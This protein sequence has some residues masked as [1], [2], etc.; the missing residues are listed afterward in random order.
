MGMLAR[1]RAWR[2]R[3]LG[4]AQFRRWAAGFPLTRPIARREARA[5]FDLCAGFVYSQILAACVELDLFTKLAAG[6]GT[7]RGLAPRLGLSEAAALRLLLGAA[8]LR[9]AEQRGSDSDGAPLFGLGALGAALLDNPGLVAMIR[10]HR[11]L[12]ADLAE[13]VALL[14]G[15]REGGLARYWRYRDGVAPSAPSAE[16]VVDY[17]GLM[18]ASLALVADDVLDS[19]PVARHRCLLDIGGGSGGFLIAA[20]ARA[21]QLQLRLFDLP[22]VAALAESRLAAAGLLQRAAVTGGDALHDPLPRGADLVSLV[23]VIHDHDDAFALR[24]LAKAREALA[25]GGTLLL[26]EPMAGV[27]GAEP[28]GDAY[29]GFYL[30]AMGQGRPRRP[31]ELTQLLRSAGFRRIRA[32]RTHQ[33]LLTGLITAEVDHERVSN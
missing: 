29:F 11:L 17:S 13:P 33:P 20:A 14:R 15:E 8:A 2:D 24:I 25:P 27:A 5:L 26:A 3:R 7:A 4:D 32:H 21:P 1:L 12:Y 28:M 19:Y 18:A 23:R 9:L 30:L 22:A 10:H 6:P 31:E 16:A